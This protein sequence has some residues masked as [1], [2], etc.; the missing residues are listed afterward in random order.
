MLA[1][2]GTTHSSPAT[3]PVKA[4]VLGSQG[5]E[6]FRWVMSPAHTGED[7]YGMSAIALPVVCFHVYGV[8]GRPHQGEAIPLTSCMACALRAYE[9]V[10]LLP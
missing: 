1:H 3:P 9:M 8:D 6:C 2:M 4:L 7:G 5:Y 10:S